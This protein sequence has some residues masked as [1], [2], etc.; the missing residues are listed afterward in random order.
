MSLI[1]KPEAAQ[2]GG[3]SAISETVAEEVRLPSS[4]IAML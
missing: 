3:I 1:S 4:T 2:E